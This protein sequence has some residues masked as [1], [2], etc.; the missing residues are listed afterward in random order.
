MTDSEV[1]QA[2][3]R[4]DCAMTAQQNVR[5]KWGKQYWDNVLAYLLRQANRLH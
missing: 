3:R 5:S 2:Y 1:E 4:I